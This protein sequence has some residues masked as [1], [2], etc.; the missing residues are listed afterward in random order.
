MR[1]KINKELSNKI[2]E[3]YFFG[4]GF[5]VFLMFFVP[6][7]LNFN[8]AEMMSF[9]RADSHCVGDGPLSR[10]HCFGDFGYPI[11]IVRSGKSIWGESYANPTP[12]LSHI[13]FLGISFLLAHVNYSLVITGFLIFLGFC[14]YFPFIKSGVFKNQRLYILST[15]P[16]TTAPFLITLD[17]GNNIAWTLPLIYLF[18]STKAENSKLQNFYLIVLTLIRPQFVVLI[19]IYLAKRHYKKSCV[20]IMTIIGAHIALLMVWDYKNWFQNGKD[21]LQQ[22]L[23]YNDGVPGLW[24]PSLSAARGL[25]TVFDIL[26]LNNSYTTQIINFAGVT[27][28]LIF[29]AKLLS[30]K[31]ILTNIQLIFLILP[32]IFIVPKMTWAY[33]T[34]LLLIPLAFILSNQISLFEIGYGSKKR[35]YLYIIALLTSIL[36]I[37]LP[38]W[39]NTNIFQNLIPI[40]WI[41]VFL[42]F[43]FERWSVSEIK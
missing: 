14:M 23:N 17:R 25:R 4:L 36:P 39:E 5:S 32:L 8:I 18:V 27:L 20:V 30:Y 13:I 26:H 9:S 35:G 16:L 11:E 38:I 34:C 1:N 2:I 43:I 24:P 28:A 29:A 10:Y 41:I 31:K 6:Q 12:V 37:C 33:Y 7:I 3:I 22:M 15:F 40:F 19:L 42:H 21:N